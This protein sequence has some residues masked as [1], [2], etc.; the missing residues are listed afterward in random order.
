MRR[1]MHDRWERM[2][3]EE[4]ERIRLG[5]HHRCGCFGERGSESKEPA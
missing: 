2:T 5:M 1:H 3:P 4:R